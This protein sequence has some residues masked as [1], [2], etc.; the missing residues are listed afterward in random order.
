MNPLTNLPITLIVELRE[1]QGFSSQCGF[2][3]LTWLGP[4]LYGE[5]AKLEIYN[6]ARVNGGSN[7]EIVCQLSQV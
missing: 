1:N 6:Q 7:Y 5:I 3:I 2:E 4:L